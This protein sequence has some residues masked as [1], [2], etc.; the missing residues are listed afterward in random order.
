MINFFRFGFSH[1]LTA[2]YILLLGL[3]VVALLFNIIEEE[4]LPRQIVG[5]LTLVPLLLRFLM[6]K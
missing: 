6:I 3:I 1:W 2:A 4:K 5:A